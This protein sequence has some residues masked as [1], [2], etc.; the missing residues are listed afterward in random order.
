MQ[1]VVLLAYSFLMALAVHGFSAP[2]ISIDADP[3]QAGVQSTVSVIEGIS[4]RWISP[5]RSWMQLSP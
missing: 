4:L 1:R 2:I 3:T 5:C